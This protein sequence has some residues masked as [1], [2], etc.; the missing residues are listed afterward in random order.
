MHPKNSQHG[1]VPRGVFV[2]SITEK[3]SGPASSTSPSDR[4]HSYRCSQF[5]AAV[6]FR[7]LARSLAS[8]EGREGSLPIFSHPKPWLRLGASASVF[9]K[10]A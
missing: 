1:F 10:G 9:G 7:E 8:G 5:R 3:N 6:E 2:A 4:G